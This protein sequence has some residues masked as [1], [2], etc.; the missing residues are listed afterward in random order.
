MRLTLIAAVMAAGCSY[1]E[2]TVGD[3]DTG[4]DGGYTNVPRGCPSDGSLRLCVQFDGALG[5]TVADAMSHTIDATAV[6]AMTRDGEAAAHVSGTSSMFIAPSGVGDLDVPKLTIEMWISPDKK[7]MPMKGFWM[8]DNNNQYGIEYRDDGQI[9]CVIKDKTVDSHTSVP[10]GAWTHVACT[11]DV[12][13]LIVFVDGA[14]DNC[15]DE[16][17][18]IPTEGVDGVAIGA[19]LGAGQMFDDRFIGGLDNVRVYS[20]DLA[21]NEICTIAGHGTSCTQ[22]CPGDGE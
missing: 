10:V 13:R 1:H 4:P 16:N 9:R 7:P 18:P 5:P 19:N 6:V 12:S 22:S 17:T 8:L 20:R 3:D 21:A 15:E 11:Y 2:P 14:V